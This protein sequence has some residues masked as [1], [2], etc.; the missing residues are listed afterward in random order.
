MLKLR[1]VHSI[2]ERERESYCCTYSIFLIIIFIY[3]L[4]MRL[5]V[6]V[7]LRCC[8]IIQFV[9]VTVIIVIH[10]KFWLCYWTT[11]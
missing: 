3:T 1:L 2:Y 9:Y 6:V 7:F 8:Q 11:L 10:S 4:F 5:P